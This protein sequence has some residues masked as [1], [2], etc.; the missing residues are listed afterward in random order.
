MQYEFEHDI[1]SG[2]GT[3]FNIAPY[4]PQGCLQASVLP[5]SEATTFVSGAYVHR[6]PDVDASDSGQFG[7]S[8]RYTM[9]R[10]TRPRHITDTKTSSTM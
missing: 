9:W 6:A 2:C 1:Y 3:Y 4:A 5:I 7:L 10:G 8:L